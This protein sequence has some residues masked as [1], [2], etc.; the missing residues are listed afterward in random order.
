[1]PFVPHEHDKWASYEFETLYFGNAITCAFIG[2]IINIDRY[3]SSVS[4]AGF[5]SSDIT[6]FHEW[7]KLEELRWMIWIIIVNGQ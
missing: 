3:T 7:F 1:M 5:P 4:N 6:S 2:N